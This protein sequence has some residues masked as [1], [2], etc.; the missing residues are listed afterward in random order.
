MPQLKESL[1]IVSFI[2]Q[3]NTSKFVKLLD[4]Q[5]RTTSN[6][7]SIFSSTSLAPCHTSTPL[8]MERKLGRQEC[9]I[10]A[11]SSIAMMG[12]FI[13][14]QFNNN[15]N[16]THWKHVKRILKYLQKTKHFGLKYGKDD[17]DLI[18][19]AD[20][21]WASDCVDRKSYTGLMYKMSGSVISFESS[22][23]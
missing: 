11:V 22:E 1:K 21:D 20:A 3:Y 10:C 17:L 23:Q 2:H 18:C 19:Y 5:N 12:Q 15:H 6:T 14:S 7:C 13:L 8:D 9:L 4:S 16:K